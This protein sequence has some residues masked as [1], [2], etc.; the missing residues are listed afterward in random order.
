MGGSLSQLDEGAGMR[1]LLLLQR[2]RGGRG[3]PRGPQVADGVP[4]EKDQNRCH[5][6]VDC[7]VHRK[8]EGGEGCRERGGKQWMSRRM[9]G[10]FGEGRFPLWV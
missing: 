5:A 6:K 9:M 7:R 4:L 3:L 2:R 10:T 1:A 8:S